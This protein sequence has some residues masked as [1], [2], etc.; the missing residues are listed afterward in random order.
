VIWLSPYRPELNEIERVWKYLKAT[1]LANYDFG[2]VENLRNAIH[3][4][5]A[6]FKEDTDDDLTICF[7]DPISKNLL[8]VA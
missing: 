8:Q 5:V 7:R 4:V 1:S 2:T 3:T 6:E